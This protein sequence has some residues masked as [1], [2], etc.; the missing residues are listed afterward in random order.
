MIRLMHF[1][2]LARCGFFSAGWAYGLFCE[3]SE[4]A[5]ASLYLASLAVL[6]HILM[7]PAKTHGARQ[8]PQRLR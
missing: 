7:G 4:S 2:L 3:H 6:S 8:A 1:P 5:L